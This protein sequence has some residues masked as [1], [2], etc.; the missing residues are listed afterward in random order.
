MVEVINMDYIRT[1][2]SKGLK[3]KVVIYRHA[4]KNARIPLVTLLGLYIPSL[5]SGAVIL[6][7]VFVWPGIGKILIDSINNRDTS[8]AMACLSFSAVLMVLG[9]LL[10]DIAYSFVDPRIKV[11][12]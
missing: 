3:E 12:D 6:E 11:E 9:N 1:A 4:F 8:L 5:F 10:A 2:R 7:T